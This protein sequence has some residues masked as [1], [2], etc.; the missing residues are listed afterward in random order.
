VSP[1]GSGEPTDACWAWLRP[2]LRS[3]RSV[4]SEWGRTWHHHAAHIVS[5]SEC[6]L[7]ATLIFTYS[8]T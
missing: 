6:R 7:D 8:P 5:V 3:S 2:P 1:A 4:L